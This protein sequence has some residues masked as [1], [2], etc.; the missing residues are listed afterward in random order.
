[1]VPAGKI[2]KLSLMNRMHSGVKLLICLGIAIL[3]SIIFRM[4]NVSILTP[5]ILGWDIFC[6]CLLIFYWISFFTTP[7]PHIPRQAAEDDPSRVIIFVIVLICS[8]ASMLAVILLLTAKK[9]S[10]A[11]KS[12]H[13]PL[14]LLG[15]IF[16][17]L[18]VHTLFTVRYAHVYY[19]RKKD[20]TSSYKGGLDFPDDNKPDFLDFA[21][22][23]FVLG[24]TFQVSD[25][26]I[27][28]KKLRRLALLHGLI[29]FAYNTIIVALTINIIAGL[30]D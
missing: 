15:M 27:S 3:C 29:S 30:G 11:E 10:S 28:S 26:Q 5:L 2:D 14:A 19:G 20:D 24:M 22:F 9:E 13:V 23:S 16:S 12:L 18:T 6:C 25:V 8:A 21:Y 4:D 7:Q 1:M 17:W